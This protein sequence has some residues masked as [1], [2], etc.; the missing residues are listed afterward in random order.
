MGVQGKPL[1]YSGGFHINAQTTK[2]INVP[3]GWVREHPFLYLIKLYFSNHSILGQRTHLAT[4][5]LS[6]CQRSIHMQHRSVIS[7]ERK[8]EEENVS[9]QVIA[10]RPVMDSKW[11]AMA[12]VVNHQQHSPNSL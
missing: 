8:I 12:L 5:K 4:N 2:E 6:E 1:I 3:D 10:V 11:N 7:I 9:M